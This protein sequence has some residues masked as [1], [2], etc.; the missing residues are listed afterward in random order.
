MEKLKVHKSVIVLLFLSILLGS[1]AS[2][3]NKYQEANIVV[4]TNDNAVV[5]M[6]Y[7]GGDT[8]QAGSAYGPEEIG[9]M[10]A[11]DLANQG[12]HDVYVLIELVSRG[13]ANAPNM[14]ISAHWNMWKRSI[15][16]QQ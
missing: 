8:A 14:D 10:M 7:V 2:F 15:Y 9:I 12:W 3:S 6:K 11:N 4:V 13:N 5:G 16:K 1:C